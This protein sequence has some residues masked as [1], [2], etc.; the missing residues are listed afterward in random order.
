MRAGEEL[1]SGRWNAGLLFGGA[2]ILLYRTLA[3]LAGGAALVLK[4][5][6]VALTLVE[7]AL[8]VG[9]HGRF[10]TVVGL[11]L[12]PPLSSA[13]AGRGCVGARACSAC[14][15]L[16]ARADR[17]LVWTSTYGL[18]TEPATRSDGRGL[19]SSSPASSRSW[20]QSAFW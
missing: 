14:A 13:A 2:G 7:M 15:R 12:H 17:T 3:L 9:H 1:R 5:W 16:C 4:P 19:R 18:S 11:P 6:V 10:G 20:A 8:D